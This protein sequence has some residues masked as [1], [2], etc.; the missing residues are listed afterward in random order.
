M[1]S[2]LA[3]GEARLARTAE[4]EHDTALAEVTKIVALRL[5]ERVA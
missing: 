3:W 1:A 5:A 2:L 4:Q